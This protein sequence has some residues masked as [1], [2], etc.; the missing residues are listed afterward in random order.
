VL[1]KQAW[2][3][4]DYSA[5]LKAVKPAPDLSRFGVFMANAISYLIN[6]L[7]LV[8]QSSYNPR[9]H[10]VVAN[11]PVMPINNPRIFHALLQ[12]VA[13]RPLEVRLVPASTIR[14]RRANSILLG[15]TV[16]AFM[17]SSFVISSSVLGV[18]HRNS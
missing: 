12:I 2:A 16:L 17:L 8:L 11:F 7:R 15:L 13:I 14:P 4:D 1:P 6:R 9:V 3:L 10:K 5:N 18:R